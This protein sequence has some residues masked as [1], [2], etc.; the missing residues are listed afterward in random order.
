M[1]A[2][3][4]VKPQRRLVL[5]GY[6]GGVIDLITPFAALVDVY[7][8]GL[9]LA[10]LLQRRQPTR[11][12]QLRQRAQKDELSRLARAAFLAAFS[13]SHAKPTENL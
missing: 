1:L 12:L 2:I 5:K 10:P 4:L 7:P 11:L 13:Q 8:R 3:H 9:E 6:L